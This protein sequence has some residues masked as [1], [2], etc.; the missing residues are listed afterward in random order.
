MFALGPA[1]EHMEDLHVAE[2]RRD[3]GHHRREHCPGSTGVDQGEQFDGT[4]YELAVGQC[5]LLGELDDL[6]RWLRFRGNRWNGI[7]YVEACE[8]EEVQEESEMMMSLDEEEPQGPQEIECNSNSCTLV[9]KKEIDE[10]ELDSIIQ[11]LENQQETL[12]MISSDEE[13]SIDINF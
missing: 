4:G 13:N 7:A 6:P 1:L 10:K 5:D 11:S 9:N 8:D 3:V 12:P 2:L